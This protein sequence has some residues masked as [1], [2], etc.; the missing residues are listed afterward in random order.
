MKYLNKINSPRDVK[1]LSPK[2][3]DFLCRDIRNFLI[4]S[5]SKTGGHLSSNLGI[6]ELTVALHYC[7]NTPTDK[8]IWDV[9]HQAYVHKILTGRKEMFNTLRKFEGL[10]GFPKT[11]ESLHDAFGVGHSSTAIS[12]GLGMAL[13]RDL[14]NENYNVVSIVGDGSMTGGLC[15]EGLNNA[16]RSNTNFIVIL[17]DNQMSISENV[18]ALSRHLNDIRTAPVYL[19]VKEDVNALLNKI[20]KIGSQISKIAEKTKDSIRALL[21]EGELFEQL[22]FNYVGPVDGHNLEELIKVLNKVKKMNAP[23][24]L[25]IYTTKGKGYGMA[26]IAPD[27]FHGV[28]TF[29]IETGKPIITKVYDTYSDVFGKGIINLASENDKIVAVTAAMPSGTG[30]SSFKKRFPKRLFDVGI[31]EAHAVTFCA[32]MAMNGFVPIFAVYSSFLQRA[33]DQIIHD[34]CIQNLHVI[35]A[36]DRAGIVGSD[37]ETHQGLFDIAFL[38]HIPNMTVLAPKNKYELLSMLEFAVD[39]NAPIS[40]RYPRGS[41]SRTLKYVNNKIELGKSELIEKGEKIAIICVGSMMDEVYECYKKLKEESINPT[42]INARFIKPIDTEMVSS[43]K[44]YE[45]VFIV[46]EGVTSGGYSSM[47]QQEMLNQKINCTFH[48]FAFPNEFI[49]QG[50]RDEIFKKYGLDSESI[51]KKILEMIK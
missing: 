31:A 20:P 36:I 11:T 2:G 21:V 29:D 1:K 49:K 12:A 10:S 24:L 41:A 32:G 40:I 27:T 33:Y 34:V 22:G 23:V 15:Y 37:G 43:L 39:F 50:S 7:F 14:Q 5:V 3:L 25:H 17:N 26:E 19:G 45:Y 38:S 6:V 16:G 4:N 46:E 35:F 28:D 47:V 51:F 42:L 9:G 8:L 30:L 13:S 18:G 48:A 44:E